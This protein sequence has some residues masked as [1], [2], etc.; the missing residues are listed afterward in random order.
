MS[1]RIK[2][3]IFCDNTVLPVKATEGSS[4]YDLRATSDFTIKGFD[5][6]KGCTIDGAK[7]GIYMEIPIGYQVN[8][9]PK[10]G[11]AKQG[12]MVVNA[13]GLIDSDYRQEQEVILLK[14]TVGDMNFSKGEKIAQITITES[15]DFEFEVVDSVEKLSKTGRFGGFGSTGLK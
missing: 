4:G 6:E 11:L 2:V 14:I 1:K 5:P 8:I 9:L 7:T 13:P 15:L 3:K 12:L 10:S